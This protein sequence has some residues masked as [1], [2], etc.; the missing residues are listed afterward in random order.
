[1][2]KHEISADEPEGED[3]AVAKLLMP[4]S[5]HS[6]LL[7]KASVKNIPEDTMALFREQV[8]PAELR[9]FVHRLMVITEYTGMKTVMPKH[10]S[11][12]YKLTTGNRLIYKR[13]AKR[14][15]KRPTDPI[16]L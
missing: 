8:F 14:R 1:M 13:R 2:P 11:T 3:E 12:A 7:K 10:V 5:Q 4:I 16:E 6:N 15:T 9:D